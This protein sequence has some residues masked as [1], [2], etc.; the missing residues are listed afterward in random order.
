MPGIRAV[1]AGRE[2]LVLKG[3]KLGVQL[4][5]VVVGCDHKV[6]ARCGEIEREALEVGHESVVLC[7]VVYVVDV[8]GRL[9]PVELLDCVEQEV[10][11]IQRAPIVERPTKGTCGVVDNG[12]RLGGYARSRECPVASIGI[13]VSPGSCRYWNR[14]RCST[15]RQPSLVPGSGTYGQTSL[16]R[17]FSMASDLRPAQPVVRVIHKAT[18]LSSRN[19]HLVVCPVRAGDRVP[20]LDQQIGCGCP[21]GGV[22]RR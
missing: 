7:N 2:P 19:R 18:V 10:A 21:Q 12:L 6:V 1:A 14:V 8:A 3:H 20:G 22:A 11:L 15:K 17:N 13:P 4:E 9:S 5:H 16:H